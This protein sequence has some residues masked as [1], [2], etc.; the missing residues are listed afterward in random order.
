MQGLHR[1]GLRVVLD[2]VYNHTFQSLEDGMSLS[3]THDIPSGPAHLSSAA[4]LL[5]LPSSLLIPGMT[6]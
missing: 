4:V 3:L 2:V 5:G 6:L 1:L